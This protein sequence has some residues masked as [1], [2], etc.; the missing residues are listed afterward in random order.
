M[1]QLKSTRGTTSWTARKI[2]ATTATFRKLG[3]IPGFTD[4]TMRRYK[5]QK[6]YKFT[7]LGWFQSR[8]S[9]NCP[10]YTLQLS[11]YSVYSDHIFCRK[12]INMRKT[13]NFLIKDRT[14]GKKIFE[15][16][17][18]RRIWRVQDAKKTPDESY[19]PNISSR[20]N[21]L[22]IRAFIRWSQI[23]FRILLLLHYQIIQFHGVLRIF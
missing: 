21:F 20:I 22:E 15:N 18:D 11:E 23:K 13:P 5:N 10:S 4:G 17:V 12:M 1:I 6:T 2:F 9:H 19:F 16:R 3:N 7:L 8:S 14:N